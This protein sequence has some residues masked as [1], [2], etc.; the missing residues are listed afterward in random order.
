MAK[1]NLV[2]VSYRGTANALTDVLA[3]NVHLGF[4]AMTTIQQYLKMGKLRA[5]GVTAIERSPLA[6]DL[7]TISEAGI[8]GYQVTIW[9]GLM[10]PARTPRPIIDKLNSE[11][12]RI[13]N[14]P[15]TRQRFAGMGADVTPT[16]PEDMR[17]FLESETTRWANVV[18]K[19]GIRAE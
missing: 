3:G 1:V 16:S 2:L 18:R 12:V 14:L 19:A 9:T 15:E 5:L 4:P 6:P 13:L 17:A 10:A 8:P 7:P 11:I